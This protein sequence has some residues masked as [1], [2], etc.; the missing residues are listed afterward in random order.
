MKRD[1]AIYIQAERR[2]WESVGIVPR[3]HHLR[4]EH[5]GVVVRVQE[6]GEGPPVLLIHGASNSGASWAELVARLN[7]F[8]C[9]MLDRPGAGLSEPLPRPFESVEDLARFSDSL[10]VDVLDALE[11]A[12]A[13]LVATSSGGYPTLRAAAAHPHRIGRVVIFGWTMGAANP[14]MPMMMR[15]GTL[16]RLAKLMT[17]MPINERAVRS[18]F[19][20]IGLRGALQSGRLSTELIT[21]FT[22]LLRYTDTLSN[23]FEVTR[24]TMTWKG[25]NQD[26]ILSDDLLSRIKSPV[27]LLWGE[28]DPFGPP[29]VA[30]SFAE[31]IPGAE[32][33]LLPGAGHAAWLD[34]PDYAAEF[35]KSRLEGRRASRSMPTEKRISEDPQHQDEHL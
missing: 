22:A 10:V 35:T 14:A 8:R 19:K 27:Y 26:I 21:C 30:R 33:E 6:V 4:L 31:R 5:S 20:R 15:L 29:E 2:L 7:G 24:W 28:D 18:M 13:D 1:R 25:L 32:L 34:D 17:K 3:E 12:S 11:C 9:L 16:P 23:E